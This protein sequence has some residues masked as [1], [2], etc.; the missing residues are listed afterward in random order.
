MTD[1]YEA[2]VTVHVLAAM[3]WIGGMLFFAIAAPVLRGVED[4][5]VRA[6]LF[7]G[8]GRRFRAVGWACVALLVASGV[9][10]LRLRGWWGAGFWNSSALFGTPLGVATLWKLGLVGVMIGVQ[11]LHDFWL[12]P[13]AGCAIAGSD[14][15]R[16]LRRRAA[17]LAR[18][19]ALVAVL[20]VY[21]AVRLG[22]GG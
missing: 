15:A 7:D 13:K 22:R 14:E 16:A 4:D 8:M 6:R 1:L 2:T 9:V 17:G 11:G 19:N 12:G 21:V 20:L 3:L 5:A 18:F 10:Q